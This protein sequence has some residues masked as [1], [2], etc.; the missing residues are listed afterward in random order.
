MS[1]PPKYYMLHYDEA[2]G[3]VL[4]F[5]NP[6]RG[7]APDEPT[8]AISLEQHAAVLQTTDKYRV[9]NGKLITVDQVPKTHSDKE[10]INIKKALIGG[11]VIDNV[12]YALESTAINVLLLD[13]ASER[14]E[15]RAVVHTPDGTE[16][17]TL[18]RDTAVQIAKTISDHLVG[19]YIG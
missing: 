17:T 3:E 15:I 10:P 18:K 2:T 6:L 9:V 4:S 14:E 13:I 12:C 7:K 8:I 19:L 5:W 16:L 1:L 11:L